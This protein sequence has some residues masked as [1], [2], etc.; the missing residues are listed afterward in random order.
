MICRLGDFVHANA[1]LKLV[2]EIMKE[3]RCNQC[4]IVFARESS[5]A[6]IGGDWSFGGL[7]SEFE[8]KV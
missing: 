1:N 7:N 6:K 8:R 4:K 3:F 2:Y 5:E